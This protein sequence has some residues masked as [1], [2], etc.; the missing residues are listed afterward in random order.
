MSP[1][2]LILIASP[3]LAADTPATP[4]TDGPKQLVPNEASPKQPKTP[5]VIPEFEKHPSIPVRLT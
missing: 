4:K 1:L 3:L 2:I 5:I